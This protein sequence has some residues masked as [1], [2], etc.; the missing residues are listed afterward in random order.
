MQDHGFE[1]DHFEI[2]SL[3]CELSYKDIGGMTYIKK[4]DVT[5]TPT[6]L[7]LSAKESG[8]STTQPI[9]QGNLEFKEIMAKKVRIL[10]LNLNL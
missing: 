4:F 10:D 1:F 6:F 9:F 2:P 7:S 8:L 5:L 3:I